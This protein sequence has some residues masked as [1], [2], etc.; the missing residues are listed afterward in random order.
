M[1]SLGLLNGSMAPGIVFLLALWNGPV[2]P[3]IRFSPKPD[4]PDDSVLTVQC[5]HS[6]YKGVKY[7]A[8]C[9]FLAQR[10]MQSLIKPCNGSDARSLHGQ[11]VLD[12][13]AAQELPPGVTHWPNP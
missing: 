7:C 5:A 4:L 10:R 13:I 1:G 9:G 3:K 6:S 2:T 8:A 11:R 12:A